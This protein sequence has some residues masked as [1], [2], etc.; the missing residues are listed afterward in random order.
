MRKSYPSEK[1]VQCLACHREALLRDITVAELLL[2][3]RI[4]I[5][6]FRCK[7]LLDM[8]NIH[9]KHVLQLNI[10]HIVIK[11]VFQLNIYHITI[12]RVLQLNIYHV[13]IKRAFR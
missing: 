5:G 6:Q 9:L 11:R 3:I 8:N 4:I 2:R 1:L 12:K 13:I 10:C 7:F